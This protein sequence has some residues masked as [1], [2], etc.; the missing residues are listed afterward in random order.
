ML[1]PIMLRLME[2]IISIVAETPT[3]GVH[4]VD[5]SLWVNLTASVDRLNV[6]LETGQSGREAIVG[7]SLAIS[8]VL[9]IY[10]DAGGHVMSVRP[11]GRRHRRIP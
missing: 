7:F 6:D 4:S 8:P 10:Y 1:V 3:Y 11:V 5:E 2:K 9:Q